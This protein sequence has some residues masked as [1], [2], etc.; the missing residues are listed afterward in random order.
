DKERTGEGEEVQVRGWIRTVRRQKQNVFIEVND[1]SSLTNLQI[2]VPLGNAEAST[3]S[4]TVVRDVDKGANDAG[5]S[6]GDNDTARSGNVMDE[7]ST[8]CSIEV[9]GKLVPSFKNPHTNELLVESLQGEAGQSAL[10]IIG[11]CDR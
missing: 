6:M 8:G 5:A 4:H 1:G 7:L 11:T 3:A 2:V 9:R 10:R